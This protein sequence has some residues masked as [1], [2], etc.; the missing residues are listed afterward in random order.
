MH[1][2]LPILL[3]ACSVQAATATD[4]KSF[5]K[6]VLQAKGIVIVICTHPGCMSCDAFAGEIP[7]VESDIKEKFY[8]LDTY[9]NDKMDKYIKTIPT[10]AVFKDG[11]LAGTCGGGNHKD[12]IRRLR[13]IIK[14]AETKTDDQVAIQEDN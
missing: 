5:D 10:L 1:R 7:A 2:L 13:K 3:V 6:D 14:Y 12:V 4:D 8:T 9:T 11:K